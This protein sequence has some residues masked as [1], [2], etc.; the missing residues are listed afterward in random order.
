MSRIDQR[1]ARLETAKE[2]PVMVWLEPGET[3]SETFARKHPGQPA[4]DTLIV[5]KWSD[6]DDAA[7]EAWP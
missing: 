3:A 7:P 5:V 1:I 4:P 6:R 2:H